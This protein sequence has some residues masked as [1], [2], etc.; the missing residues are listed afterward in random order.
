MSFPSDILL[1]AN[2]KYIAFADQKLSFNPDWDVNWSF[3]YALSGTNQHAFCVFFSTSTILS[4]YPGHY[5]GYSGT[6]AVSSYLLAEDNNMLLTDGG[7]RLVVDTENGMDYLGV[8]AIAFD[9]TGLFALSS[10]TRPGVGRGSIKP[11]SIIIRDYNDNVTFYEEL[12]NIDT[13]FVLA[14]AGKYFQTMR[15]RFANM[16]QKLT[17]DY[18]SPTS[19]TYSVLT[20][21]NLNMDSSNYPFVN[22]GF[23]YSSPVSSST[24]TPSTLFLKNFHIQ[25]NTYDTSIETVPAISIRPTT[26]SNYTTLCS[27]SAN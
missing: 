5:M 19:T 27:V 2:A 1:P 7:E 6:M 25:G 12:S 3:E 15:F 17:I 11:N 9:S 8:L 16:G 20:S 22:V 18:K 21:I 13:N 14:S 4:G 23:S 10:T 26:T 24:A